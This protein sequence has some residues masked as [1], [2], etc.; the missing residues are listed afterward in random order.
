MSLMNARSEKSSERERERASAQDLVYAKDETR[1]NGK[2]DK[3]TNIL[4]FSFFVIRE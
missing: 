4:D 3:Q 1:T 2:K